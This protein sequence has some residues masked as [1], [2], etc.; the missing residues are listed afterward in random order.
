MLLITITVLFIIETVF[1]CTDQL[2]S[3]SLHLTQ[4]FSSISSYQDSFYK[5]RGKLQSDENSMLQPGAPR[6]L[7]A[8]FISNELQI[9]QAMMLLSPLTT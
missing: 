4:S 6:F 9:T 1:F 5:C 8:C 7:V 2:A 3:N